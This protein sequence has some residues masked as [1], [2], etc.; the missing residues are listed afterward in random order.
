MLDGRQSLTTPEGF[1]LRRL[2]RDDA[3]AGRYLR[4]RID[5]HLAVSDWRAGVLEERHAAEKRKAA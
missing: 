4:P 3:A 5:A 1:S 2:H